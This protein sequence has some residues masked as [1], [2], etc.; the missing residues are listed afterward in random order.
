MLKRQV[1][2][3]YSLASLLQCEKEVD[4]CIDLLMQRLD[5]FASQNQVVDLGSWLQYY[6]FDVGEVDEIY[7]PT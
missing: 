5:S 3:A 1:G 2:N 7:P 4:S 6:A